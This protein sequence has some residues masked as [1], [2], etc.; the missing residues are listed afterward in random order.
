M[1]RGRRL[2]L[3]RLLR[4]TLRVLRSEC[5]LPVGVT[6]RVRQIKSVR[7]WF[8]CTSMGHV[9]GHVSVRLT[10]RYKGPD[11]G[12]RFVTDTEFLDAINHEWAHALHYQPENHHAVE[13]HD[14]VWGVLY[15]KAYNATSAD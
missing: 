1:L 8:G 15:A 12:L 9:T 3:H 5:P 4:D 13:D 11:G 2:E 10:T 14:A 7:P 6:V